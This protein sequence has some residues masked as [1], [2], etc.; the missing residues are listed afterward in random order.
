MDT[1]SRRDV[2]SMCRKISGRV[3]TLK[4]GL[5]LIYSVGPEVVSTVKSFGY[6]VMLDAKLLDIPNTVVG[7]V[8][9]IGKLD[10]DIITIHALGGRK[11]M[12]EAVKVLDEQSKDKIRPLLFGVTIL[13]SLDDEDLKV[14]GFKGNFMDSVLN[15]IN[16]SGEAGLDGIVCSPRE[17][18]KVRKVSGSDFYIA[19]PGIRLAGDAPG[20]Q[21]RI[22]TPFEAMSAGADFI[23]AGRSIT[24]GKDIGKTIDL[25]MDNIR[26]ALKSLLR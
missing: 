15:L 7:T 25:Y 21:K 12:E 22:S 26:R 13:T 14:L 2:I 16:I 10:V 20:D 3:S 18:E 19:T 23:I 5:E 4:L 11:M 17:V 8:R 6:K 9:A 24:A 1:S